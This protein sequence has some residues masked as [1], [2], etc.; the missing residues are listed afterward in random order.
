MTRAIY[1]LLRQYIVPSLGAIAVM[2][3]AALV[4]SQIFHLELLGSWYSMYPMFAIIFAVIYSWTAI[5]LYRS[6]A[7]SM[8]CRRQDFFWAAQVCFLLFALGALV[9]AAVMGT[10]PRL[11]HFGYDVWPVTE[12]PR[13]YEMVPLYADPKSWP[14]LFLF[15]LVLQYVGAASGEL[16][17]HHKVLATVLMGLIMLLSVAAVVVMMFMMDGSLSIG[18]AIIGVGCSV[19]ALIGLVCDIA[20]YRCNKTAV[21]R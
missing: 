20:F 17:Y 12:D 13:L 15:T 9:I 3:A 18:P 16:Y 19:M 2:G 4:G 11:L 14:I 6:L 7:L 8:N 10:L 5:L 1:F 21:V